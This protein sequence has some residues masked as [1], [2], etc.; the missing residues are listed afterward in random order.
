MRHRKY[1]DRKCRC[2]PQ[3]EQWLKGPDEVPAKNKFLAKSSRQRYR[4][5]ATEFGSRTWSKF[6][7]TRV[8]DC[9]SP[10]ALSSR[11]AND[12]PDVGNRERKHQADRAPQSPSMRGSESECAPRSSFE[13]P[14]RNP[15]GN[16]RPQQDHSSLTK[17]T[18]APDVD[19]SLTAGGTKATAQSGL[20][21]VRSL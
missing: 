12:R 18:A 9:D 1:N 11:D 19:Q 3:T 21:R 20:H 8:R 4:Y 2:A 14:Q 6:F 10:W 15:S 5:P 7:D 16:Q 13:Q 17:A